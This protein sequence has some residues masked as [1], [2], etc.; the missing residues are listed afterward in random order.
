MPE[1]QKSKPLLPRLAIAALSAREAAPGTKPAQAG[2]LP[3]R[4]K[5]ELLAP[6]AKADY[7]PG[8]R[9]TAKRVESGIQGLDAQMEGGFEDQS[10]VIVAGDS[11][12]GKTTFCLQ[13]LHDGASRLGEPGIYITFE[14]KKKDI[15]R[16]ALRFG[17][18]LARLEKEKK[19][20]ILE[21]PPHEIERFLTEGQIVE[22]IIRDIGAKRL[23]IDSV[24]SFALLFEDEYRRRQ[25]LTSA[26]NVLKKWGCTTLM[27]SEAQSLP[28]GELRTRFELSFLSDGLVYLY[29]LRRG[30]KRVRALEIMKMRGTKHNAAIVPMS[31]EKT[32]ITT[33]PGQPVFGGTQKF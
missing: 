7:L 29:N 26:M 9:K 15:F 5:E 31:F 4:S 8:G 24:T 28:N 13:F 14:E 33:Y 6:L 11:G 22:D 10:M 27:T 17:W 25:G 12:S 23:I 18:D 1:E 3:A 16:R 32:G 2:P 21:Y 20:V 30:D 19:L